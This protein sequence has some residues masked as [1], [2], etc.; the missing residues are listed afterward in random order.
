MGYL[1]GSRGV[2]WIRGVPTARKFWLGAGRGN[3]IRVDT[4][5]GLMTPHRTAWLCRACRRMVME[6]PEEEI[7]KPLTPEE[8]AEQAEEQRQQEAQR[9][10]DRGLQG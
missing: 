4:E 2:F 6:I 10:I 3:I 8:T 1:S 5:G 9:K 7:P